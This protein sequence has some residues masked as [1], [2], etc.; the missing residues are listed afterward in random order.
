MSH[1]PNSVTGTFI[2]ESSSRIYSPYV[3]AIGQL[4]GELPY[5]LI[6]GVLYWVLMVYPQGFGKGS[7]GLDGTGFQLLCILFMMLFGVSFGQLLSAISPSVQVAVLF[8]PFFGL[9]FNTFC[10]VPIP[11]PTMIKFWRAWLYQVIP[12]TRYNAAMLSTELQG[13]EVICEPE[14]FV[15]FS[16]PDGQT[17]GEWA[18]DFIGKVGGYLKDENA[19]GMCDYCQ[20]KWG[21]QFFEPLNIKYSLRWRDAFIVLAFFGFNMLATIGEW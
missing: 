18:N 15:Q 2:R 7:A 5:S 11:Y 21:E 8:N 4:I 16:A 1:Q 6:A 17:C 3:F 10:G 9:I 12:F 20:Y 19:T 14:E 13:L